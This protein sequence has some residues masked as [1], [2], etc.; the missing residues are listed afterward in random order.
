VENGGEREGLFFVAILVAVVAAVSVVVV[1]V[2]GNTMTRK[3]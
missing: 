3:M 2:V 1:V